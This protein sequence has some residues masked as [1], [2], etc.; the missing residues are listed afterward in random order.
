[1]LVKTRREDLEYAK[2]FLRS[3]KDA[4]KQLQDKG[5]IRGLWADRSAL[6]EDVDSTQWEHTMLN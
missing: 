1:M 3:H 4:F 2:D 6:D 5:M